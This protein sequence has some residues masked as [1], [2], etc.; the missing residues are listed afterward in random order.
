MRARRLYADES[1]AWSWSRPFTRWTRRSSTLVSL[2]LSSVGALSPALRQ[3]TSW[4]TL[5]DLRGPILT[6]IVRFP[7]ENMPGF[8]GVL[9]ANLFLS[10]ALFM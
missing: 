6:M 2:S 5:L 1:L 9:D 7:T 8:N 3:A 4:H 10:Q